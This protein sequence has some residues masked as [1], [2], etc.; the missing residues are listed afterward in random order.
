M[1]R[2]SVSFCLFL[3]ILFVVPCCTPACAF[4][5]T[6]SAAGCAGGR[7]GEPSAPDD[8]GEVPCEDG[9]A[10]ADC[11]CV[12]VAELPSSAILSA[13]STAA[14]ARAIDVE[15]GLLLSHAVD[16]FRRSDDGGP[17]L[18]LRLRVLL[19]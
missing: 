2:R 10:A 15:N 3:A 7:C 9:C 18:H 17:P 8:D 19:L 5:I 4:G 14:C 16:S 1:L 11:V 13:P 6:A 12:R